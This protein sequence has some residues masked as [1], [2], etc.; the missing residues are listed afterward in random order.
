MALLGQALCSDVPDAPASSSASHITHGASWSSTHATSFLR[1]RLC[2]ASCCQRI[3]LCLS[4]LRLPRSTY[5]AW[6]GTT[7]TANRLYARTVHAAYA[8][9]SGYAP[10]TSYVFSCHGPNATSSTLYASAPAWRL[11]T[12][13]QRR[14]PTAIYAADAYSNTCISTLSP[15]S[16]DATRRPISYDDAPTT[17]RSSTPIRGWPCSSRANGWARMITSGC[18]IFPGKRRGWTGRGGAGSRRRV[19]FFGLGL[20]FRS[21]LVVSCSAESGQP[22]PRLFVL[23][24]LHIFIRVCCG[25][26]QCAYTS[27]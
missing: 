12:P 8:I 5:D 9:S 3:C 21:F 6:Y 20:R 2:C 24:L 7:W 10:T 1:R 19:L 22:L 16:A 27:S 26:L 11:S 17:E 14:R 4:T 13:T 15:K 18:L 23:L 25:S